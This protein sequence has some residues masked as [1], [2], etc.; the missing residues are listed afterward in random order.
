MNYGQRKFDKAKSR[1]FM[2]RI[3]LHD[4]AITGNGLGASAETDKFRAQLLAAAAC[5]SLP[6][7]R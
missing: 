4:V 1:I 5:S 6:P 3:C 2:L 7:E